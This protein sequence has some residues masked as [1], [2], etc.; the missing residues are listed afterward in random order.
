MITVSPI[1]GALGAEIA[2]VN[3]ADDLDDAVV[4]EIRRAWLE[5]LVVFFRDQALDNDRFMAFAQRIGT[6][7]EYPFVRGLDGYPKIIAVTKLPHEPVSSAGIWRSGTAAR[8]APPM[9]TMLLA[10]EIPPVGGDTLFANMY[11]AYETLSS[12]MQAM[13]QP[14]RA[15]NSSA[16]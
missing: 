3:L 10:R 2:G 15:I 9:A 13:L 6:P 14:L 5:H 16:L 7:V 1:A 12:R 8:P 4:A 11:A